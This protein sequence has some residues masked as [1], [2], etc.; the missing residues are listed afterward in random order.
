M[1]TGDNTSTATGAVISE[2]GR[3]RYRLWRRWELTA[4]Q[5]T[6]IMLN[7]STADATDD[8]PTIRRCVRFAIAW[9]Y[10]GIDVVNLFGLR[11]TNPQQ[12]KAV[13]L[14]EALGPDNWTHVAAA[15]ERGGW[16]PPPGHP[17]EDPIVVAA[18]GAHGALHDRGHLMRTWL[19]A[20]GVPVWCLRT[21]ADGHPVHPL[22]RGRHHV[23][24]DTR[25]QP[26]PPPHAGED[27]P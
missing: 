9:G 27:Q 7:P 13:P 17:V 18:W 24:A 11:A 6:W 25:P 1:S 20:A 15:T 5:V 10:G 14:V 4:P 16:Y 8:D 2:C 19:A 21:T 3:Y 26:L 22:A 23:P 12:V